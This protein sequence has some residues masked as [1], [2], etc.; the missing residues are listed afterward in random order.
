MM[1]ALAVSLFLITCP[2]T[3][4]GQTPARQGFWG[5]FGL[6][7]T[8]LVSGEEVGF[9]LGTTVRLGGAVSPHL[10]VG[11]VIDAG[12]DAGGG[13]VAVVGFVGPALFFYPSEGGPLYLKLAVGVMGFNVGDFFEGPVIGFSGGLGVDI[14]AGERSSVT[15]FLNSSV[16]PD[17]GGDLVMF[18]AG[19][20]VTWF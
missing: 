7:G 8:A 6:G 12:F 18:Q 20:G 1:R 15:V 13:E 17:W 14:S 4:Q 9:G 2:L 3:L 11:G 19:M 16:S 10:L 5:G